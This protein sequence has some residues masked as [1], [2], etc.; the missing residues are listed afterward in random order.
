MVKGELEGLGGLGRRLQGERK[1]TKSIHL[2]L[3]IIP[4]PYFTEGGSERICDWLKSH[5]L[6]G[7]GATYSR[8][9]V[10]PENQVD[11]TQQL[12]PL[13]LGTLG[14]VLPWKFLSS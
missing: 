14:P 6:P 1:I 11:A 3:T 10:S 13:R 5:R 9:P 2:L 4:S 8:A 12:F 7:S